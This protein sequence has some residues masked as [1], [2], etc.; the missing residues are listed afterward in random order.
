MTPYDEKSMA[1][2]STIQL[3][4]INIEKTDTL[5]LK[6]VHILINEQLGGTIEINRKNGTEYKLRFKLK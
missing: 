2:S 5:G 1:S 6:L 3:Q 4:D